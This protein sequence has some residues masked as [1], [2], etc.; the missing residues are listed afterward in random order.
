M[1]LAKYM[2]NAGIASRRRSEELIAE[3][4]V[5]VNGETVTTP[6][7]IVTPGVDNVCFDGQPIALNTAAYIL[8]NKPVGYT[9]SS[10]DAHA[11]RLVYDLLP[12]KLRN[13][14]YVGRLD[15]DTEGLLLFTNDGEL[16]QKLTHPSNQ[17]EKIYVAD[18]IGK[19]ARQNSKAM[20]EGIEDDGELLKAKSLRIRRQ[21][22]EHIL[23]EL[24]LAEGKKREVRRLCAACGLKVVR[25]ARIAL[26]TLKLGEL[27]SG[28][29]RSLTD[30]E[31]TSLKALDY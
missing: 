8:L 26:G 1:R 12:D 28:E 31:V 3:G 4:H 23:L 29:W 16:I 22:G 20:L 21:E 18:C 10:E 5:T 24:T 30:D 9:C 2:S 19:L 15:R 27:P 11:K 6:V 7:C 25:L 13:L 14:R 17:V